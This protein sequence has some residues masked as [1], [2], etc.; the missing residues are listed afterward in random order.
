[1]I[2]EIPDLNPPTSK[3]NGFTRTVMFQYWTNNYSGLENKVFLC[4][5]F[6]SIGF[7]IT[8]ILIRAL[9][10]KLPDRKLK[11][12]VFVRKSNRNI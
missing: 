4:I 11:V 5:V 8:S 12:Y 10:G 9:L 2:F 7:I 1:M 6:I 3:I